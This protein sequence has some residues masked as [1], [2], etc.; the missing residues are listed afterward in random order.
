MIDQIFHILE[1]IDD[2]LWNYVGFPAMMIAGVLLTFQSR[3]FQIRLFP[4]A[5]KN[6]VQLLRQRNTDEKGVHPI[7]AFFAC[8]GGCIGIGNIVG[9]C[10][11]VQIGGPGAMF[12]VWAA[13]LVGM[14]LKYS[15][16]YVGMRFRQT[17]PDGTHNGGPMYYLPQ[18]FKAAWVPGLVAILLCVY[19]VELFQ[20]RVMTNSLSENLGMN[21]VLVTLVLLTLVLGVGPGGL[22]L[23]GTISSW[24][25]PVFFVLYYGMG[26]Y[27]CAAN[28]ERLPQVLSDVFVYAFTPHAA[29]GGALGGV[30]LTM[31]Y[32]IR[33]AC[34]SSDL[35]VG[36]ASVIHSESTTHRP[37]RQAALAIIDIFL[38]VFLICTMSMMIILVTDR[39]QD[40]VDAMRLVEVALSD[41]FPYMDYFMSIFFVLLG[42][43]T[44]IAFLVVGLKSAEYLG[45]ERG[46]KI[47][48]VYAAISLFCFSFVGT[49]QAMVVM[50]IAQ[51]FLV[52]LNAW[53]L[54]RL[55]G[56]VDYNFSAP[57]G[58]E[59][60]A[61]ET[62]E[63]ESE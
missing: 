17:N 4:E 53:G 41:Y 10:T 49:T 39:W 19:G 38:D 21:H 6:F 9:V 15:E 59:L 27:V 2:T 63:S 45:G 24:L 42:Y 28:Y 3:F 58:A 23:V 32:G 57:T 48:Y 50:S 22:A 16:V 20:F 1:M 43:S 13:A 54:F 55:R 25:I 52:V 12:W 36:Y 34:Y 47:Y 14:V 62:Q 44:V 40:P 46:R 29:V 33:R 11:A 51:L 56:H 5:L 31:S 30:I 18:A 60:A 37:D 26:I 35:C 61:L 7:K 8:V